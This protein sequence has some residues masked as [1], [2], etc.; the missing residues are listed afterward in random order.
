[1]KRFVSTSV[2]V[3]LVAA[4]AALRAADVWETKPFNTWTD[5]ELKSLLEESPWSGK[6]SLTYVKAGGELQA[7]DDTIR[8]R[9]SSALPM[10]QARAREIVG[11]NGAVTGEIETA[12]AAP[13]EFYEVAF[14][15]GG[16]S[17]GMAA[18]SAV[19]IAKET[20]LE[21][22]GKPRLAVVK[23]QATQLDK[24]GKVIE[25]PTPPAPGQTGGG[26]GVSQ[27]VGQGGGF[28][29]GGQGG[30][31]GF[32][33]GGFGGNSGGST[34]IVFAFPKT[35][36]ITLADKEVEIVSKVGQYNVKKKFKLKDMVVKGAL[37]I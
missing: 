22:D 7:I 26:R 24:N 9:W 28:G 27:S 34:V 29:G 19:P 3:V 18:R 23:V 21:R 37:A 1:M 10:R 11:Q 12:L 36:P 17:G 30:G 6:A 5:K 20:F 13:T 35:D 16:A 15:I 33:R 4:G 32:G 8:V 31:G 25:A 2:L 14:E